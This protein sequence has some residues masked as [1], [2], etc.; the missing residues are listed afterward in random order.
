M[1]E[2]TAD[3]TLNDITFRVTYGDITLVDADV[4]VSSDDNHLSMGGGIGKGVAASLLE[5]GGEVIRQDAHKHLPLKLGDVIVTTAGCLPAKYIFHAATIDRDNMIYAQATDIR[6][7]TLRCLQLADILR[8]R[9]IAFPALGTGIAGFSFQQ[10]AEVITRTIADYLTG[11]T[12]IQ[13]VILTLF[14][15]KGISE[16]DLSLFYERAVALASIATQSKR[17]NELVGELQHVVAQM[18]QPD[19][20][21]S[22]QALQSQ[23]AQAQTV[24]AESPANLEQLDALEARSGIAEVSQQVV[25]LSTRTQTFLAQDNR[26]RMVEVLN[27]KLSGLLTQLNIQYANLNKLQIKKAKYGLDTPLHLENEIED[28]QI[29]ISQTEAQI[30]ATRRQLTA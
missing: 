24:L 10:A 9:R 27:T 2:R 14:A 4:L 23:L 7:I 11:N 16:S 20:F 30:E 26:Q 6:A 13:L 25:S 18:N 28:L 19:L 17:L 15:A 3:Y 22:V 5:A 29:E 21:S 12:K 8:M 1:P